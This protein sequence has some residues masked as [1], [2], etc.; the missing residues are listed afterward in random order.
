MG[1]LD[2][3]RVIDLSIAMAGPLAAMRLGD[4]GADVVKVEPVTGEWQRHA[5]AGGANGNRVNA[6]FLSL[7]RN[8][9]SLAVNLKSDEGREIV[10][11]LAATA[12]VF[13]Q[14]YRPGVAER[15]GMDYDTI[16]GLNPSIVYVSMSGYGETGPYISRPGQDLLLQAMSGAMLST[17]REGDPPVPAGSY[18][19]DAITAYSAFE[20]ALAAL[21][22]RERTGEGQRVSV[23]MLDAA[24]AVQ[25]QELSIYTVGKVP[26]RRGREP[27]GHTYIRAPY[28]VFATKDGFIALGMPRL[29]GLA[30]ALD[31]P[32]LA[33]M[34]GDADGHTR[35]D[36][37]TALVAGRLPER[38]T[39][40]WLE[41]CA[42]HDLW[43]GPVYG[44]ADLVNDP[45]VAHNGSFVTY[46]HPT[47]GTVTTPGFP[48]RFSATP[49]G[50]RRGAPL[51]GEHTG[52]L[53][54][55]L[56]YPAE[57]TAELAAEGVLACEG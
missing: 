22:H 26:Q 52:E 55:E 47:E 14:N 18:A 49:P 34:D 42:R 24:V 43:A 57:R 45:Q 31:L 23:N 27:H 8:K 32:E 51:V 12:D 30:V 46:E 41:I 3:I 15:L 35:R 7:N 25:M 56:G 38:T 33:E 21:L 5:P 20:G 37:I 4:L 28:G 10:H 48:Y 40:E 39:A 1:V 54:E 13:L 53:L 44:Y 11:K 50:V 6:S 17:G 29:D 2:G 16:R 9:R 19:I 36:E